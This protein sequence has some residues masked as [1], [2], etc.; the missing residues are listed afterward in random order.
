MK[1]FFKKI[2]TFLTPD[3]DEGYRKV[4]DFQGHLIVEDDVIFEGINEGYIILRLYTKIIVRGSFKGVVFG[5]NKS[6][7]KVEGLFK[8]VASIFLFSTTKTSTTKGDISARQ[9]VV[10]PGCL[11]YGT[12]RMASSKYSFERFKN[13]DI[14]SSDEFLEKNWPKDI[15]RPKI[16]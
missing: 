15:S 13:T 10:Q 2:N 12:G 3:P 1:N 16:K 9:M 5:E 7:L 4:K 6:Q 8:G 11:F 14:I